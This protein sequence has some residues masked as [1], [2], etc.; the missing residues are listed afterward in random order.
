M[1]QE[2]SFLKIFQYSETSILLEF[3][4]EPKLDLLNELMF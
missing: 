1:S 3:K 2:K 4:Q